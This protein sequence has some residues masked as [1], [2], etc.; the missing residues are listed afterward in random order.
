[1]WLFG[2][3][4]DSAIRCGQVHVA[5]RCGVGRWQGIAW[6]CQQ[7]EL[8]FCMRA[9]QCDHMLLRSQGN[10]NEPLHQKHQRPIFLFAAQCCVPL[11]Q[12]SPSPAAAEAAVPL[13]QRTAFRCGKGTP[14]YTPHRV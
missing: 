6:R 14:P 9:R 8:Q 5:V 2:H 7:C 3:L 13:R 11:T 10:R 12:A 4:F 1:M